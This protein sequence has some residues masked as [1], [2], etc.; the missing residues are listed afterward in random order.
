M[1]ERWLGTLWGQLCYVQVIMFLYC[2]SAFQ[3]RYHMSCHR[4]LPALVT[5]SRSS[6]PLYAGAKPVFRHVRSDAYT[7]APT[8]PVP[9]VF[10]IAVG[11]QVSQPGRHLLPPKHPSVTPTTRKTPH[12]GPTEPVSVD[13]SAYNT[14]ILSTR[15]PCVS[16]RYFLLTPAPVA[17]ANCAYAPPGTRCLPARIMS[18]LTG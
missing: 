11:T 9:F 6:K 8:I 4:I 2:D 18:M 16:M 12:Q 3:V 1:G 13:E 5:I 10:S 14:T 17:R 15:R 7:P